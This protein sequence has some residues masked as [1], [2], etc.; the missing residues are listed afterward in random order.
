MSEGEHEIPG[1]QVTIP[2]PDGGQPIAVPIHPPADPENVM[3]LMH[4]IDELMEA[5]GDVS[6]A[7][8][9]L[10]ALILAMSA[11]LSQAPEWPLATRLDSFARQVQ[12]LVDQTKAHLPG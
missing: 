5:E 9:A 11:S 1:I 8:A 6:Y 4:A 2:G 10:A 12:T 3:R 7:D